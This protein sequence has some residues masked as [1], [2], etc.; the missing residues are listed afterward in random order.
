ML[1]EIKRMGVRAEPKA[2]VA[3]G[4]EVRGFRA[5]T[6]CR[7]MYEEYLHSTC[8]TRGFLARRSTMILHWYIYGH[9]GIGI[10][11]RL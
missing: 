6:L 2:G 11:G 1:M 7:G 4:A 9:N 3:S 8:I 5:V 10:I